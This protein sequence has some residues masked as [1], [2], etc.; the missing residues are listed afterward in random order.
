MTKTLN[1]GLLRH[2][3]STVRTA[4]D[5]VT[6]GMRITG[7]TNKV[8]I[9]RTKF[10]HDAVG[11]FSLYIEDGNK[12]VYVED[13]EFKGDGGHDSARAAIRCDRDECQFHNLDV[14]QT[15]TWRRCAIE[16]HGRDYLLYDGKY[17]SREPPVNN[18]ADDT[19]VE[20]IY[21]KSTAGKVGARLYASGDGVYLKKNTLVNGFQDRGCDNLRPTTTPTESKNA[22]RWG[23]VPVAGR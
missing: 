9:K 20:N 1:L 12:P 11:G 7:K 17:V 21:A 2:E 13:S 16:L 14:R 5:E 8:R 23:R 15:G 6:H 4:G 18:H 22:F 19:W 10:V 3:D